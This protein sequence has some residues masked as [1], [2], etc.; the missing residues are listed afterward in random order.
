MVSLGTV[1][2]CL[3]LAGA[4]VLA[5]PFLAHRVTQPHPAHETAEWGKPPLTRTPPAT[6]LAELERMQPR[7]ASEIVRASTLVGSA[8]SNFWPSPGVWD[9]D[10]ACGFVED[11]REWMRLNLFGGAEEILTGYNE[12]ITLERADWRTALRKGVG[13]CSQQALVLAGFLN[14][15]GI[16]SEVM[17]LEGHVVVTAKTSE[18]EWVLDPAYGVA[19]PFP[20]AEAETQSDRV[21]AAYRAAGYGPAQT[22]MVVD[23]Y[24]APGNAR[25][26]APLLRRTRGDGYS[27]LMLGVGVGLVVLSVRIARRSR[28]AG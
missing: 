18:G 26:A 3:S 27:Y 10:L 14:E 15:H 22:E 5:A 12:S 24:K 19:L 9:E 17:R 16:D 4:L 20:L 1:G 25:Y 23:T 7:T 28:V 8:M 6:V 13:Y 11:P 2:V 21:R